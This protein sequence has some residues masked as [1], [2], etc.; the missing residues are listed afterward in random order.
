VRSSGARDL[1]CRPPGAGSDL[2]GG[3]CGA[4]GRDAPPVGLCGRFKE[5][6]LGW[7]KR[8][9]GAEAYPWC[10]DRNP[11][12]TLDAEVLLVKMGPPRAS[13]GNS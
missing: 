1:P 8:S 11:Y 9:G 6:L 5:T 12:R 4:F 2:P 3:P 10:A 7:W 13:T